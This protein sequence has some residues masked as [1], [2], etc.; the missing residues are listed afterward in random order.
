[1]SRDTK[2]TLLE[3]LIGIAVAIGLAYLTDFIKR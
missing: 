3:A 2:V 1:M